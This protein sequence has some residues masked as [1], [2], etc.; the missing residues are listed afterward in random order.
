ME[1]ITYFY[2]QTYVLALI[3]FNKT[4]FVFSKKQG[5][6][7]N[8]ITFLHKFQQFFQKKSIFLNFSYLKYGFYTTRRKPRLYL[9][10]TMPKATTFTAIL[11]NQETR[12]QKVTIKN[13]SY[14]GRSA[15]PGYIPCIQTIRKIKT[16]NIEFM[17][18]TVEYP[19]A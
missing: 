17:A 2:A 4:T 1:E 5:Y 13:L 18:L 19:Y 11:I 16:E 8:N 14:V 10:R 15:K 6:L 12:K 9:E 7:Y 3:F